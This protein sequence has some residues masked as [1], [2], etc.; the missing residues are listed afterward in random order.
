MVVTDY[1]ITWK[2]VVNFLSYLRLHLVDSESIVVTTEL[3]DVGTRT[4]L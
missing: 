4:S 3:N 2:Y 1:G